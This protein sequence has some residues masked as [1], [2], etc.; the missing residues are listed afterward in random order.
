MNHRLIRWLTAGALVTASTLTASVAIAANNDDNDQSLTGT[1][2]DLASEAALVETGGGTV[3]ETET[4]DDGAAYS[5]EVRTPDGSVVEVNLDE[6]FA[7][8][9]SSP[10]DDSG[11]GA[12]ETESGT[13]DD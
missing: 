12:T 13:D 11:E 4:G 3:I 1:S 7:V 9:G 6:Q 8:T 2:L 10:D 5:V